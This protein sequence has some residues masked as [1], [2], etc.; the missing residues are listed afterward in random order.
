[1]IVVRGRMLSC[2]VRGVRFSRVRVLI[3]DFMNGRIKRL[4]RCFPGAIGKLMRTFPFSDD[5]D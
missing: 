1:M 5:G 4:K 3:K 2:L